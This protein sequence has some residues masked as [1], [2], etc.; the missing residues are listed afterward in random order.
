[1][2]PGAHERNELASAGRHS[3]RPEATLLGAI[4]VKTYGGAGPVGDT[5]AEEMRILGPNWPG[6]RQRGRQ[7]R[8]ILLIADAAARPDLECF[9]SLAVDRLHQGRQA[10]LH[11]HANGPI[12]ASAGE[13]LTLPPESAMPASPPC[14]PDS[15]SESPP[16]VAKKDREWRME[17]QSAFDPSCAKL[18]AFDQGRHVAR[19]MQHPDDHNLVGIR[20][21]VDGVSAVKNHAQAR[22]QFFPGGSHQ[23]K[24]LHLRE[25]AGKIGDEARRYRLGSLQRQISPDFGKVGFRRFGQA[26]GERA[27]NSFLPRSTMRS[28]S[29]SA[30]RPWATSASPRSISAFSAATS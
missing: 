29:K 13:D 23:G 12:N 22:C 5:T 1:M 18:T 16:K 4:Q 17:L 11:P 15:G 10:V 2:W 19:P 27:A 24:F 20:Q 28:A 21:V 26:E 25:A 6:Q 14:V 8:P 7:H 30:T 3:R 9:A